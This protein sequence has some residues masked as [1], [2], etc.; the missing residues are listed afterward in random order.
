VAELNLDPTSL[1]A[2]IFD[3][4]GTLYRQSSLRRAMA[5]RLVRAHLTRPVLGMRTFRALE[6]YRKAQEHLRDSGGGP[7]EDLAEVQLRVACERSGSEREF[8]GTCVER[9]MER[10]PLDLLAPRIRPGLIEFLSACRSRSFK[11]G[12]LSDY[13]AQAKLEALGLAGQF[14]LVMSAQAPEIGVFKPDPRGLVVVAA[15]LGVRP[16]RCL[17]VGDRVGVD[18]AAAAAAG[19]PVFIV[20]SASGFEVLSAALAAAQ[21]VL[22]LR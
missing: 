11:L 18:D 8:L 12:V 22:D 19:M 6:A 9:W 5:T 2:V 21:P 4:D 14:D 16:E 17:Y 10:E 20:S 1:E 13:P 15:R 3:V 7:Y